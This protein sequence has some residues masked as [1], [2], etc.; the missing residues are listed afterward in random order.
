MFCFIFM[1]GNVEKMFNKRGNLIGAY[2][3]KGMYTSCPSYG[4]EK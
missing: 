3:Q 1:E 2:L 4:E